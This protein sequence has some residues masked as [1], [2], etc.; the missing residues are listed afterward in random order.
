MNKIDG[1]CLLAHLIFPTHQPWPRQ[2]LT[3]PELSLVSQGLP[4]IIYGYWKKR[5]HPKAA[6]PLLP[7]PAEFMKN[8][9]G[10]G[11]H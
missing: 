8:S 9:P 3:L 2:A 7:G 11:R 5:S 6:V 10:P 1:Y 4:R